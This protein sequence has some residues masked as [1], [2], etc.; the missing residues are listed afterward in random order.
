MAESAEGWGCHTDAPRSDGRACRARSPRSRQIEQRALCWRRPGL[1]RLHPAEK[2]WEAKVTSGRPGS[3]GATWEK[4]RPPQTSETSFRSPWQGT[5]MAALVPL[6]SPSL[7][8]SQAAAKKSP[9]PPD[10]DKPGFPN[11]PFCS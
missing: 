4:W 1:S 5:L 8:N 2:S 6:F 9:Q 10:T 11:S 7:C 3:P